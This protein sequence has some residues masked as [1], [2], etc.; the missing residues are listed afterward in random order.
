MD[1]FH[2]HTAKKKPDTEENRLHGSIYIKF[3]SKAKPSYTDGCH[4]RL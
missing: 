4:S 3:K 1:E 2:R